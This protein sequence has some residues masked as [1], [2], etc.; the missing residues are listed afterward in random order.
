MGVGERLKARR[1]LP[2]G[3]HLP[4]P[5]ID[6]TRTAAVQATFLPPLRVWLD[7][8]PVGDVR[9]LSLRVEPDALTIII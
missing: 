4:H 1:R 7:G 6:A 2:T 9:N 5:A 3:T 8:T